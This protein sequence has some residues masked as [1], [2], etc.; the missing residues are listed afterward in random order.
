MTAVFIGP[1]D[2]IISGMFKFQHDRHVL[3]YRMH[4][5]MYAANPNYEAEIAARRADRRAHGIGP[6]GR[7]PR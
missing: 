3:D 1:T 5:K 4:L 2:I 6:E 7:C